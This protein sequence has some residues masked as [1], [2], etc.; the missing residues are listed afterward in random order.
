MEEMGDD[1]D[2]DLQQLARDSLDQIPV[3]RITRNILERYQLVPRQV[4]TGQV[5]PAAASGHEYEFHALL[6]QRVNA[7]DETEVLVLWR[8]TWEPIANV[9]E[10]DV[11]T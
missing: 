2:Q 8:P 7:A 11:R 10:A 9:R 6:R 3:R 1:Q 5:Y 4:V